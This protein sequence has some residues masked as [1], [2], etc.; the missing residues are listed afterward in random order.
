MAS[1]LKQAQSLGPKMETVME[2]LKQKQVT[3][4]AAG[5]LV[6]VTMNGLGQVVQVEFDPLITDKSDWEMASDL[7]PAAINA[8]SDKAKQLHM[9]AMQDVTGNIGLPGNMDEMLKNFLGKS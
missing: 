5:G 8:A 3:G 6:R 7:L 4:E 1:L 9:D 2:E